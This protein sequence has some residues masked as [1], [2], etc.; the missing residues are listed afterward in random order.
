MLHHRRPAGRSGGPPGRRGD[1]S[2]CAHRTAPRRLTVDKF[3]EL[4]GERLQTDPVQARERA[5]SVLSALVEFVD[6]Q[7]LADLLIELPDDYADL[8][9]P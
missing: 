4:L 7:L 8:L 9:C 6:D 1:R 3:L 2:G 5:R